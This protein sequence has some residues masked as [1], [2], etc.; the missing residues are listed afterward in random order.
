ML[1]E[2]VRTSQLLRLLE[3]RRDATYFTS[4]PVNAD[5]LK[6]EARPIGGNYT[7]QPKQPVPK[8]H[9]LTLL[10][11]E[12]TIDP[13][14]VTDAELNLANLAPYMR[15]REM[16]VAHTFGEEAE[17]QIVGG[18]GTGA[19]AKGL[20][21]IVNGTDDVDPFGKTL[22]IDA[23]A[24]A[25]DLTTDA[26]AEDIVKI[27]RLAVAQVPGA[28]LLLCNR[29]IQAALQ[30]IADKRN[31]LR[32]GYDQFGQVVTRF[33]GVAIVGLADGAISGDEPS[34]HA[35][36]QNSTSSIY[37]VRSAEYN[38]FSGVTNNGFSFS[39]WTNPSETTQSKARAE[40]RF[41]FVIE[42]S[43]A[44]RRIRWIKQ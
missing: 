22:T 43:D 10:G 9:S 21:R 31:A 19:N 5:D 29:E 1:A 26:G 42:K 12:L 18:S 32:E 11:E 41:G 36:A 44:V 3:L 6:P 37:V 34:G 4:Y 14:F 33:N 16:T 30:G 23:S 25:L 7:P 15:G 20:S 39:D 8:H 24:N 2:I 28:N 17:R 40:L 38:G 13:S 27:L 35:T